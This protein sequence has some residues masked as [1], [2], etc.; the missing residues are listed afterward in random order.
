MLDLNL[1]MKIAYAAGNLDGVTVIEIGP[2]PGGLTRALLKANAKKVIA[3][4]PEPHQSHRST[5]NGT[6][7]C[8]EVR[9]RSR[10]K[11]IGSHCGVSVV[12]GDLEERLGLECTLDAIAQQWSIVDHEN[13][14]AICRCELCGSHASRPT[15]NHHCLE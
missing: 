11:D 5:L 2:G 4:L 1:T 13:L 3:V 10:S 15:T 12:A 7:D 6:G 14:E 8:A 9:F